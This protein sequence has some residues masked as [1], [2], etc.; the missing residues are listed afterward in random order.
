M[1]I[2]GLPSVGRFSVFKL[3]LIPQISQSCRLCILFLKPGKNRILSADKVRQ[4]TYI[5]LMKIFLKFKILKTKILNFNFFE[6]REYLYFF[7][8]A[9]CFLI[10]QHI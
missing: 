10:R 8:T 4:K 7:N 1:N 5:F 3:V 9:A 6:A 2:A